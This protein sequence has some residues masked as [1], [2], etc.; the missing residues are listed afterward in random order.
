MKTIIYRS[1]VDETAK[2]SYDGDDNGDNPA[3]EMWKVVTD[4][5]DDASH[6]RS[7][8]SDTQSQHH[9]EEEN[10]KEL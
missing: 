9:Q 8:A 6:K 7:S 10:R 1:D 3:L 5:G 2:E 4:D